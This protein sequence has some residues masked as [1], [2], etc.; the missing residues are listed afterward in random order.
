MAAEPQLV[1]PTLV[2][3]S[4]VEVEAA[5]RRAQLDGRLGGVRDPLVLDDGRVQVVA[6]LAPPMTR[7][8][9]RRWVAPLLLGGVLVGCVV[10]VVL[11]VVAVLSAVVAW[12]A[13]HWAGIVGVAALL[14]LL[15]VFGGGGR[16]PGLHCGGCRR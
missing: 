11:V 7:W 16:C 13:A 8:S 10:G 4:R 2:V 3:G 12:V 6:E 15:A 1:K 14:A 5:L 9:R